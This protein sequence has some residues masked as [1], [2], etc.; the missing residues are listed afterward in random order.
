MLIT[1]IIVNV[2]VASV[3]GR[4]LVLILAGVLQ[5]ATFS[6]SGEADSCGPG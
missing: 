2:I 1:I 3:M 4:A 5:R 6:P